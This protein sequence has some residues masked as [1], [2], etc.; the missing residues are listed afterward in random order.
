MKSYLALLLTIFTLSA[1][2]QEIVD[3][4]KIWS[5]LT[6]YCHPDHTLYTTE[7]YEFGGDTVI[8]GTNY[9]KVYISEDEFHEE[10]FFFGAFVREVDGR[11]YYRNYSGEEGLIYD[12]NLE[13]G[14]TVTINNPRVPDSIL[15]ILSEIDTI[16]TPA[17]FRERWKLT[18]EEYTT[19]EY[20]IR[21]VGSTS[22]VINSTSN[23]FGGMC[24]LYILLCALQDETEIYHNPDYDSCYYDELIVGQKENKVSVLDYEI[25]YLPAEKTIELNF[26]S[27]GRRMVIVTDIQGHLLKKTAITDTKA[28]I[29]M[30]NHSKGLYV[31]TVI[32]EGS[33]PVSRKVM[34]Y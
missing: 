26:P 12:F 16:E 2:A 9:M 32:E 20:W 18:S 11:V 24:G 19:P 8:G 3:S 22:G 1:A 23:I 33:R 4:T 7:Y 13:L 6:G 25:M 5:N 29:S 30:I 34:V 31:I 14:D 10:W 17:G 15:L 28:R 27:G 21:G